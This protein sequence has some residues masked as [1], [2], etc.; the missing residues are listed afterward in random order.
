MTT[1]LCGW[2]TT[3]PTVMLHYSACCSPDHYFISGQSPIFTCRREEQHSHAPQQRHDALRSS[4][5]SDATVP[6]STLTM[7]PASSGRDF[8]TWSSEWSARRSV[9]N[10]LLPQNNHPWSFSHK[11]VATQVVPARIA[12][13]PQRLRTLP[14][15]SRQSQRH[16]DRGSPRDRTLVDVGMLGLAINTPTRAS[17]ESLVKSYAYQQRET[18]LCTLALRRPLPG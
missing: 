18:V 2:N 1:H 16:H 3:D 17:A 6:S 10:V 14:R 5:A 9:A 4:P 7:P 12:P 11:R 13:H 15:L 8:G